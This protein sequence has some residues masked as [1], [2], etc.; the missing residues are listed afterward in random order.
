MLHD[1][2]AL[3]NQPGEIVKWYGSGIDIEDRK[4]AEKRLRRSEASMLAPLE[5]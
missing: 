5:S 1:K 3:R 4:C 2:V